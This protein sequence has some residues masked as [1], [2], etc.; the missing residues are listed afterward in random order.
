M[1]YKDKISGIGIIIK[2]KERLPYGSKGRGRF[3]P[4][5][6]G[7]RAIFVPSFGALEK[8]EV[9]YLVEASQ[10]KEDE[11]MKKN[12]KSVQ[13]ERLEQLTQATLQAPE[14]ERANTAREI[15]KELGGK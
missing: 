8:E 6:K 10:E 7:R 13:K 15:I 12:V 3:I 4:P 9:D 2:R 5:E 1:S 11:R 14:G